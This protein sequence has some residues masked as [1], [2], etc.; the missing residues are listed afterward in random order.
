MAVALMLHHYGF[1]IA[2]GFQTEAAD[3]AFLC[4]VIF[5]KPQEN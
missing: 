4:S 2:E 5:V 3:I 1:L